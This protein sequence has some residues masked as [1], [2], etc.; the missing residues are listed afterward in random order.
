MGNII[1]NP[2]LAPSERAPTPILNSPPQVG[3][4]FVFIVLTWLRRFSGA[5]FGDGIMNRKN[6]SK[7]GKGGV[8]DLST[9]GSSEFEIAIETGSARQYNGSQVCGGREG[10]GG[11]ERAGKSY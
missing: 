11:C 10:G 3:G 1:S 8:D 2:S 5:A 4:S 9:Q 6:G 7:G